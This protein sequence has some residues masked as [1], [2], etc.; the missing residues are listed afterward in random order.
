MTKVGII[1]GSLREAAFSK[2]WAENIATM[3][4]EGY[5]T[6]FIDV[7]LPL[8]NEDLDEGAVPAEWTKFR[9]AMADVDAVVFS[10][11]EYNRSM[12]ATIK[13]ALDV[14]SRPYGESIWDGKPAMVVSH[15]MSGLS[16]FGANHAIRQSLVFLNMPVMQQPE[17]YLASSQDLLD[18]NGK[19]NNEGTQNF[20]Q[21]TVDAFVD[22]SS[23][24]I[25]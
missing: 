18:E 10:T 5:E 14:G 20:V 6:E 19:I 16:G 25:G 11:P 12:P 7:N 3:F 21:S 2:Q 24:F 15:S 1:V 23:K 9:E 13:N 8:Y 17:V 22:F 4:P